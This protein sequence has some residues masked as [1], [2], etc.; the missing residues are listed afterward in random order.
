MVA[1]PYGEAMLAQDIPFAGVWG[2]RAQPATPPP[3][4]IRGPHRQNWRPGE[5]G[6]LLRIVACV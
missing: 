3:A 5:A 1:M 2:V 4:M 6:L